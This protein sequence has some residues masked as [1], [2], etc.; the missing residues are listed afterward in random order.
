MKSQLA[1]VMERTPEPEFAK[2]ST[3]KISNHYRG[4]L[5]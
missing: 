5:T 3:E 4:S 2:R 1:A